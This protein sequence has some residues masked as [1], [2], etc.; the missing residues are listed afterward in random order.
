MQHKSSD[1][2]RDAS[3]D[4]PSPKWP[5]TI[6]AAP[7]TAQVQRIDGFVLLVGAEELDNDP[8]FIGTV[9]ALGHPCAADHRGWIRKECFQSLGVPGHVG[10]LE[11]RRVV[12]ALYAAGL[13]AD[14]SLQSGA[15]AVA[16]RAPPARPCQP[17]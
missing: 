8:A 16:R 1:T 10:S 14:Q 12:I 15:H 2:D 6:S 5:T 9:E 3:C 17:S 4:E 7:S 13:A 11:G